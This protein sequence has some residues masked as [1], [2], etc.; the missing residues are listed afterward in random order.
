MEEFR[1]KH[2]ELS[3]DEQASVTS[4]FDTHSQQQAAPEYSKER[5]NW[6]ID[7]DDGC[8]AGALTAD[9][10]WGW[11]YIDELW[12]SETLRGQGCGK[13]LM[14]AAEGY[15]SSKQLS[16]IWLWTQ[17]WQ[18]AEFYEHLGYEEFSRFPD[19]PKGHSRI[20]YRK[21]LGSG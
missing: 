14:A 17:S 21:V 10:L 11:L 16:G 5:I 9:L 2:G 4:G 20:G 8:V 6:L 1:I 18:A 3:H 13:L 19:F 12:V 15:A 7:G